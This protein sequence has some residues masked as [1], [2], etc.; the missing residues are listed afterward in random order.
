MNG[1]IYVR[2]RGLLMFLRFGNKFV[3]FGCSEVCK[4]IDEGF[5]FSFVDLNY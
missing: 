2:D 5:V 1:I 4:S 3:I